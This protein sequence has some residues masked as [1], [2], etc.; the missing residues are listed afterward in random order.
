MLDP[1]LARENIDIVKEAMKNRGI[2]DFEPLNEYIEKDNLWRE[3]LIKIEGLMIE[4][5]KIEPKGKPAKEQ[6]DELKKLSNII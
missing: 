2:K 4:R 3:K 6:L 1:K 5:K